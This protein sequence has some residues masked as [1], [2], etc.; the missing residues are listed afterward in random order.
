MSALCQKRSVSD[1]CARVPL[2]QQRSYL[3]FDCAAFPHKANFIQ[4][5]FTV[6][7]HFVPFSALNGHPMAKVDLAFDMVCADVTMTFAGFERLES[8]K[9]HF[10]PLVALAP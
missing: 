10:P 3:A 6:R 8:R 5:L 7:F 1:G 4:P 9:S 2:G